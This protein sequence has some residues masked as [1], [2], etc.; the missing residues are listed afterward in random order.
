MDP[1]LFSLWNAGEVH[2]GC[3]F[4]HI[5]SHVGRIK[6]AINVK[7]D[8]ALFVAELRSLGHGQVEWHCLFG[9]KKGCNVDFKCGCSLVL[10]NLIE[11]LNDASGDTLEE[12]EAIVDSFHGC[13]LELIDKVLLPELLL[14]GHVDVLYG[15]KEG[16]LHLPNELILAGST[17]VKLKVEIRNFE[18]G[19][20][21]GHGDKASCLC[22]HG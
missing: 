7:N 19:D 17:Q 10:Q 1:K 4:R 15:K 14:D 16:F 18:L 20:L 22:V 6:V 13:R 8:L 3:V 9:T 2:P 21:E 12:L 11:L 5:V